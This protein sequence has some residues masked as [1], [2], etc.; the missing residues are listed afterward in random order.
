MSILY[1]LFRKMVYLD[2]PGK[3]LLSEADR[4]ITN[5]F[6]SICERY[7]IPN[8]KIIIENLRRNICVH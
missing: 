8:A 4:R 5:N 6:G 7:L 1:P 2:L 3:L